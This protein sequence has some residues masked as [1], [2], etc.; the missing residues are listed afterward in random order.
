M[1]IRQLKDGRWAVYYRIKD[2]PG[3]N[4]RVK[5]E[6][7]GRGPAAEAA[8]VKRNSELG[9]AHRRP[10]KANLGPSVAELAKHYAINKNFSL[11]S[12]KHLLIRLEAN[13]LPHFGA[14]PAA[15]LTHQDI[16]DYVQHRRA[17]QKKDK[18]NRVVKIGVSWST[19]RRELTDLLAILNWSA[20]RIPPLIPFN[21]VATYKKPAEDLAIILPPTKEETAAILAHAPEH[22]RRAILISCF[23]GLRP[24]AVELLG[25]KF[26]DVSWTRRTMLVRSAD[27]GGPR[28]RDVPLHE[29]FAKL[30]IQWQA[31]DVKSPYIVTW[32]GQAVKSI[33]TAWKN[34]LKNAGITRRIRLYDLRHAFITSALEAGADLKA[35]SEVVGSR[36]ETLMRNYQHVSRALRR[37]AVETISIPL[38]I[39]NIAKKPK[40][41]K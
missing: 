20:S 15:R 26:S 27:K 11:N 17:V 32:R 25:L 31:D 18:N 37:A 30:L 12:K 41:P 39:Q 16:D 5:W 13:L 10:A 29:D 19:I 40:N 24:G 22:L 9:L 8:A 34:T 1:A 38:A 7:F 33:K 6:Y 28:R 2:D 14:L 4:S 35:L 21:P 3:S 36:P 23:I